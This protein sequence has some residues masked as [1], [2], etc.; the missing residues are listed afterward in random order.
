MED[1]EDDADHEL[2]YQGA[3]TEGFHQFFCPVC[4]G[5]ILIAWDPI[6]KIEI[7]PLDRNVN[8][9]V[10]DE[11]FAAPGYPVILLPALISPVGLFGNDEGDFDT[12]LP[13]DIIEQIE[14]VLARKGFGNA[15]EET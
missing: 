3:T 9:I 13:E 5:L 14:D 4:S 2:L 1:N 11:R 15:E 10:I 12:T 7:A 8:H 6:R